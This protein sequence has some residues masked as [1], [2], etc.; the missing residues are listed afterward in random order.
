MQKLIILRIFRFDRILNGIQKFITEQMGSKFTEPPG[1][2]LNSSFIESAP[3]IPLVF[4]LSPGVDPLSHIQR[5]VLNHTTLK[6]KLNKYV[7]N[8]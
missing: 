8:I 5:Y 7:F 3:H 1:F 6:I 2:L 4:L